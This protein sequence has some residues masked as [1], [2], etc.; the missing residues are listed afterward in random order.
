MSG[1]AGW[2]RPFWW[3]FGFLNALAHQGIGN[4]RQAFTQYEQLL[5]VVADR[6]DILFNMASICVEMGDKAQAVALFE[7]VIKV[8]PSAQ[9]YMQLGILC[10]EIGQHQQ[11]QAYGGKVIDLYPD[12]PQAAEI[13]RLWGIAD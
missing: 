13:R 7:R 2:L 3:V 6:A 4:L 8:K 1:A 12:A 5:A 10:D 11:A 9:I